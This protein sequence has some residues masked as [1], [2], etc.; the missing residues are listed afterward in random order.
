ML[1]LQ[2]SSDADTQQFYRDI[3]QEF[4]LPTDEPEFSGEFSTSDSKSTQRLVWTKFG[5]VEAFM[6]SIKAQIDTV[7]NEVLLEVHD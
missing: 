2:T 5:R 4:C 1:Y 3:V 7:S 6:S